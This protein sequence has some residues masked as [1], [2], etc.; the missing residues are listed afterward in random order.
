MSFEPPRSIPDEALVDLR[1]DVIGGVLAAELRVQE[2]GAGFGADDERLGGRDGS[3]AIVSRP[4]A[5]AETMELRVI[6]ES[7]ICGEDRS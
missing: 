6:R 4:A 7:P 2:I 3:V 5:K 1:R